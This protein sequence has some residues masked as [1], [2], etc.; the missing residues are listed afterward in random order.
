[1]Q[2]DMNSLPT[3]KWL[4]Q[5]RERQSKTLGHVAKALRRH[6]FTVRAV[7]RNDR[8]IPPGW[9]DALRAL[10]MPLPAPAWPRDMAPYRG[11]DLERDMKTCA[12]MQH[13]RFWL[14]KQLGVPDD[15]LH[16]VISGNLVVP[17]NWLLK[18]AELGASVPDPVRLARTPSAKEP[19]EPAPSLGP[20]YA[21][22][23]L[24]L[25]QA[26]RNPHGADESEARKRE[27]S[28]EPP[29]A[30]EPTADES[31][32]DHSVDAPPTSERCKQ[33][34][35]YFHWTEEEGLQFSVSAPLL[36]Q[37]PVVIKAVAQT[38]YESGLLRSAHGPKTPGTPERSHG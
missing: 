2:S 9:G 24:K 33:S 25:S 21:A 11:Q 7:E 17:H 1:M 22:L 37:I 15:L 10:G 27:E 30:G 5:E 23:L 8:V 34:S 32:E 14:S 28:D 4:E 6:P 31:G 16:A 19:V 3:G 12:G 36:E 13:S 38:L 18:L 29:D 26:A 35:I 20:D